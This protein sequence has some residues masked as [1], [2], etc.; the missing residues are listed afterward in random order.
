MLRVCSIALALTTGVLVLFACDDDK[1]KDSSESGTSKIGETCQR[2][3]DCAENLACFSGVCRPADVNVTPN[4]KECKAVQCETAADCCN[5]VWQKNTSCQ[6]YQ[7]Q[8][9]SS[10][11]TYASYCALA[12]GPNC[13]CSESSYACENNLCRSIECTKPSDCCATHWTKSSSCTTYETQCA[14]DPTTYASYCTTATGP[15]CV[16]N[17]TVYTY[18]CVKNVCTQVN[19]CTSDANCS[20]SGAPKCSEGHCVACIGDTD[21]PTAN[22][23]CIGNTCIQPQCLTNSDCPVFSNCE[24]DGTCKRVGCATDRECM[25]YMDSYLAT[26]NKSASTV[27]TCEVSCERDS[28]CATDSNPLRVCVGGRCQ[29]PGC[30]TDEECKIRLAPTTATGQPKGI[31]YV[32]RNIA[33]T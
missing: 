16:C 31:Q 32:C 12:Q 13:V 22:A 2:T 23:K 10:P 17:D 7:Q 18:G 3:G 11:T 28:Q 9:D 30:D 25:T 24:A 14:A 5:T 19:T 21:C 26:C 6:L 4:G 8:C 33:G 15:S 20:A 29:D 1:S 27:P